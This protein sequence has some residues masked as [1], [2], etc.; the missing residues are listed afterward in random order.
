MGHCLPV[1]GATGRCLP[2]SDVRYRNSSRWT[3]AQGADDGTSWQVPCPAAGSKRG[4][5]FG[6]AAGVARD[7]T[8]EVAAGR[9]LAAGRLAKRRG[10]GAGLAL[11]AGPTERFHPVNWVPK[12]APL[13]VMAPAPYQ[14][15][16]SM[17]LSH[18]GASARHSQL[19][20]T[21]VLRL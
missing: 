14:A 11:A 21:V 13:S 15:W 7:L 2:L 9:T 10:C 20:P 18:Y 19:L 1:L 6:P 17:F 12:P 8:A 16:P 4:F 3:M 5:C